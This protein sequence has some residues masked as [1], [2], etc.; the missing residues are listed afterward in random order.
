MGSRAHSA[1]LSPRIVAGARCGYGR[2][3]TGVV[4]RVTPPAPAG[5]RSTRSGLAAETAAATSD[6]TNR[7]YATRHS[8]G[9]GSRNRGRSDHLTDRPIL[10]GRW[11]NQPARFLIELGAQESA[12]YAGDGSCLYLSIE[13]P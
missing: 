11:G 10:T 4:R 2:D 9:E 5:C 12:A 13:R 6:P 8:H 1:A 7:S 3:D